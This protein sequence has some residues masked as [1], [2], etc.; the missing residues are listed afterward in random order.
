MR[1]DQF[2]ALNYASHMIFRLLGFFEGKKTS[3]KINIL[4]LFQKE[5]SNFKLI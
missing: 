1:K 5:V 2:S 4:L 3:L